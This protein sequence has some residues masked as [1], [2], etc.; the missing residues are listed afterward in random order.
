MVNNKIMQP[1]CCT[2]LLMACLSA[3]AQQKSYDTATIRIFDDIEAIQSVYAAADH[4]SFR[5]TYYM[6]DADS[7]TV[8]DTSVAEYK[9]SGEKFRL[10]IDSVESI[11]NDRYFGTIYHENRS[12]VIQKPIPL[13]RQ[14]LGVDVKDSVFQQLVM[15]G[16]I[17]SD[18]GAYRKVTILFNEN[19]PFTHYEVIFN[20]STYRVSTIKYSLR[21]ELDPASARRVNMTMEFD[22]YKTGGFDDTVFS[23]DNYFK[24]NNSGDIR[25]GPFLS[26]DY[27]IINMI[28][29]NSG[30]VN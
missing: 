14:V 27:E 29:N 1:V 15:A 25:L 28:G 3:A 6:E 7:V 16:M 10:S 2:L 8:R 4:I 17:S 24:V 18:S 21:K 9:I 11:Q 30:P 19:V 26:P 22:G 23:T 12:V 13:P 5:C 20:K